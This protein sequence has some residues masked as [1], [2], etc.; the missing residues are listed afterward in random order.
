M[1]KRRAPSSSFC[2]EFEINDDRILMHVAL[3]SASAECERVHEANA[4]EHETAQGDAPLD[5]HVCDGS[6]GTYDKVWPSTPQG[7]EI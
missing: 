4:L 1:N 3:R 5:H 7:L 2:V 6:K